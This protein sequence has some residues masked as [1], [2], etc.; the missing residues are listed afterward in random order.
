MLIR[1]DKKE[2]D[3]F[4][5]ECASYSLQITFFTNEENPKMLQ[6]E[7]LDNG[8]EITLNEAFALGRTTGMAK[9]NNAM[10]K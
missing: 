6:A 5:K 1:I 2:R 3:S 4:E 7:V 8:Q 10:F 9:L